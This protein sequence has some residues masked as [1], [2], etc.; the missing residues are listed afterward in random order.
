MEINLGTHIIKVSPDAINKYDIYRTHTAKEGKYKGELVKAIHAF[1]ISLERA[2]QI[3][4]QDRLSKNETVKDLDTFLIEYKKV[5]NNVIEEI[6][7]IS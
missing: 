4:I 5:S 7:K 1:G 6:K 2:V 3:T